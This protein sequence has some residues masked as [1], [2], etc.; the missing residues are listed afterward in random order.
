MHWEMG[1]WEMEE[2]QHTSTLHSVLLVNRVC[3][4]TVTVC[5]QV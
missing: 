4:A 5:L 3:A 1:H 2:I